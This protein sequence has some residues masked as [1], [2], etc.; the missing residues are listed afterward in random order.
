MANQYLSSEASVSGL[1][2]SSSDPNDRSRWE[3]ARSIISVLSLRDGDG[4]SAGVEEVLDL[5]G[6]VVD[7]VDA[8]RWRFR[9]LE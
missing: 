9:N 6:V 7:V 1:N 2:L 8:V 5:T 4:M 3:G